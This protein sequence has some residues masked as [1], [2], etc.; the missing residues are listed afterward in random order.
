MKCP[1]CS[2]EKVKEYV[3][4]YYV[5]DDEHHIAGGCMISNE[6]PKYFCPKCE[7]D[8]GKYLK[9]KSFHKSFLDK[10]DQI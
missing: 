10:Q 2:N 5:G 6:S 1:K 7:S 9:E 8:F 4:G 3:Y